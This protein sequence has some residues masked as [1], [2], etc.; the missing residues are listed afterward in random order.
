MGNPND[1]IFLTSDL[2]LGHVNIIR[3][4]NRPYKNV[5]EMN[6]DLIRKWNETV[7][8]SDRVYFLGDFALGNK[9][10]IIHFG[11]R[12]N[13]RKVIV[14]GN[15]DH[16]NPNTYYQA[17]FEY[18]SK[19]PIVIQGKYILTHAPIWSN[20]MFADTGG[21]INI[22]GHVHDKVPEGE[23][24]TENSACVCVEQWNYKPVSLS[25][26]EKEIRNIQRR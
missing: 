21:L 26:I 7:T 8:E 20:P 13:G 16:G 23:R 25:A 5:T 2:H 6:E 1:R 12:L 4:C 11:Q 15:H 17:G 22:Y 3:C 10:D 19:W 24:V 9:E 18:V 14:Y